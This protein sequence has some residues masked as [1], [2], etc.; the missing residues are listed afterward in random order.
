M[1]GMFVF[2]IFHWCGSEWMDRGAWQQMGCEGSNLPICR[3][4]LVTA[5]HLSR[6]EPLSFANGPLNGFMG[7]KLLNS[8]DSLSNF[9]MFAVESRTSR[10]WLWWR[11][12][13]PTWATTWSWSRASSW[14]LLTESNDYHGNQEFSS[15]QILSCK[16]DTLNSFKFFVIV[17]IVN[18]FHWKPR[19][20]CYQ[21]INCRTTELMSMSLQKIW[22][23]KK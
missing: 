7:N 1:V 15:S 23:T 20:F 9:S 2:S 17:F 22:P 19:T 21:K 4:N 13:T 5:Y 16:S 6:Y 14:S 12:T 10:P 18:I 8:K 11:A 3:T